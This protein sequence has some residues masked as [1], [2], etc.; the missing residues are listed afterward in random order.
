M[1]TCPTPHVEI[2][3]PPTIEDMARD[4]DRTLQRT[5][6]TY[7]SESEREVLRDLYLRLRAYVA[8]AN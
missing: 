2:P 6:V 7:I 1:S 4:L 5:P 8:L 3:L